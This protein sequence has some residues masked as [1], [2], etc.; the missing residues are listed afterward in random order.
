MASVCSVGEGPIPATLR[1]EH[2]LTRPSRNY[3]STVAGE[4]T[5]HSSGDWSGLRVIDLGAGTGVVGLTAAACGA[6]V[7]LTDLSES[8]DILQ[9]NAEANAV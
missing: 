6:D 7:V 8:L 5:M 2:E 1:T 4:R 3:Q 9:A